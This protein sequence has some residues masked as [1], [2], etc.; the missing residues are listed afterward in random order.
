L[1]I[2]TEGYK[3]LTDKI[4]N[5]KNIENGRKVMNLEN[6]LFI[7]PSSRWDHRGERKR[8]GSRG[9]CTAHC[10]DSDGCIGPI[11]NCFISSSQR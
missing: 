10:S 11:S 8:N 2:V 4:N 9:Y 5:K 3:F 7:H 1:F 6:I